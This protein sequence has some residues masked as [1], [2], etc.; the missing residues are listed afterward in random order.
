M[1]CKTTHIIVH[2]N[3]DAEDAILIIRLDQASET[4]FKFVPFFLGQ[5]SGS[6]FRSF[7]IVHLHWPRYED[8]FA[9]FSNAFRSAV[10]G[11]MVS[12]WR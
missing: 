11:G 6:D 10:Q 3:W 7:S 5:S 9:F 2:P 8:N 1:L 12:P 4:I